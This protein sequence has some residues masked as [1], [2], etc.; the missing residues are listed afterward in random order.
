MNLP[1]HQKLKSLRSQ[2][3]MSQARLARLVRTSRGQISALETG[4]RNPGPTILARIAKVF[5]IASADLGAVPGRDRSRHR[6]LYRKLGS[7]LPEIKRKQERPAWVRILHAR[8]AYPIARA[9]LVSCRARQDR[10]SV[11]QL[12]QESMCGSRD[13]AMVLLH[14]L[15]S[16]GRRDL[17]SVMRLGYRE[18][19]VIDDTQRIVGDRPQPALTLPRPVPLVLVPQVQVRLFDVPP[20]YP[21]RSASMDFLVVTR[22]RSFQL[23]V[24]LEVNGNGHD[25]RLDQLRARLI[26]LPRLIV[27]P[28]ELQRPDFMDCLRKQLAHIARREFRL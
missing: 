16:G 5:G 11:N 2:H 23:V 6:Q 25:S 14:A 27:T 9:L 13:E 17:L 20:D 8:R 24:N 26:G 4:R 22:V 21:Y 3:Q 1:F 15:A 12:I 19:P 7:T 10:E 28:S 18:L